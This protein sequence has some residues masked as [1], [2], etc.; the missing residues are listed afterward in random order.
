MSGKESPFGTE[1]VFPCM[2]KKDYEPV[3]A[4]V[5]MLS[6]ALRTATQ[7]AVYASL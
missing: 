7:P 4:A 6:V 2:D 5:I 3:W 1:P